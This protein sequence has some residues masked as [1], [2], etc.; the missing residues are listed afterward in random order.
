MR[1]IGVV[2]RMTT[3]FPAKSDMTDTTR[4]VYK[5]SLFPLFFE[6]CIALVAQY[7]KKP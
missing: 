1:M 6:A 7:S 3:S 2:V 4:Y 5:K